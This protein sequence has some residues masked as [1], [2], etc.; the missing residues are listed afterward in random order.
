MVA[1]DGPPRAAPVH[2]GVAK[3]GWS[4]EAMDVQAWH[5]KSELQSALCHLME[6]P[7]SFA[8]LIFVQEWVDF[9]VEMRHFIV[10]PDLSNPQTWKPKRIIYTV[11]KSREQGCFRN[12]DRY[13]RKGCLRQCFQNDEAALADA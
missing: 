6:Q 12:F 2:K 10:E 8:D 11:F 13:D 1:Q 7:G 5:N 9:D 3:L 4:W